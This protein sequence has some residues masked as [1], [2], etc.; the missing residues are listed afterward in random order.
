MNGSY[1]SID[2]KKFENSNS[3]NTMHMNKGG[4]IHMYTNKTQNEN[5]NPNQNQSENENNNV[6]T[7][8]CE[9]YMLRDSSNNNIE[10]AVSNNI[11]RNNAETIP[12]SS[13][14]PVALTTMSDAPLLH[15][16]KIVNEKENHIHIDKNASNA[17]NSAGKII[18]I[19]D[20]STHIPTIDVSR[21]STRETSPADSDLHRNHD[22]NNEIENHA[23]P[24]RNVTHSDAENKNQVEQHNEDNS[25]QYQYRRDENSDDVVL[26]KKDS[27]TQHHVDVVTC[28]DADAE[29]FIST[30]L[31]STTPQSIQDSDSQSINKNKAAIHD[32]NDTSDISIN[33]D[34][35]S[36]I[37]EYNNVSK[38]TF[39]KSDDL[40]EQ[41]EH[42]DKLHMHT[43]ETTY[44]MTDSELTSISRDLVHTLQK[45]NHDL[46][47]KNEK[48][49]KDLNLSIKQITEQDR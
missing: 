13:A 31:N 23:E 45:V 46:T 27:E 8:E 16:G 43:E 49:Q 18:D 28:R 42:G 12:S 20:V 1:N 22:K 33:S 3:N 10:S 11:T 2:A 47:K 38:A 36:V 35:K 7:N 15:E 29:C 24:P 9:A 48:L 26:V 6:N 21:G 37:L 5:Q 34:S 40:G 32:N 19:D 41:Y 39:N 14:V 44:A 25:V 30:T 4:E 17:S